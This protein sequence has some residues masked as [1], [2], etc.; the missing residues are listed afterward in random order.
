MGSAFLIHSLVTTPFFAARAFLATFLVALTCRFAPDLAPHLDTDTLKLLQAA[1]WWFVHDVTLWVLGGLSALEFAATK[2]PD[3]RALM[4]EIDPLLK[5][6]FSFATTVG[7]VNAQDA[8]LMQPALSGFDPILLWALVP[9]TVTVLMARTRAKLLTSLFEVDGDDALGVQKLTI[10]LE[11]FFVIGGVLVAALLPIL[12]LLLFLG[13]LGLLAAARLAIAWLD[14][15]TMAPCLSCGEAVH[16]TAP[17]CG[18]CGTTM[19]APVQVGVF[20]QAKKQT[21]GSLDAHRRELVLRGRCGHCAERLKKRTPDQ[22]CPRCGTPAFAS[23][24]AF[25]AWLKQISRKLPMTLGVS[26]L[27]G[28][29]PLVG[30]IPGVIYIRLNLIAPMRRYTPRALGCMTRW[31]TR[32]V[33][34]ML[35]VLQPVPGLGAATLPLIAYTNYRMYRAAL[36]SSTELDDAVPSAPTLHGSP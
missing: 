31:L 8:A 26:A 4:A 19:Q 14:D 20:G 29:I 21:V 10:W 18:S 24:E 7:L 6:G 17:T 1:P 30:I 5:G 33:N 12:A 2:D 35:I 15:R 25:D 11:D 32:G 34:F 22:S 3:A 36:T 28:L 16:P 13:S 23:P 27:F 9:A